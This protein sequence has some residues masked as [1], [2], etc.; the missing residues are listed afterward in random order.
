ML[1]DGIILRQTVDPGVCLVFA[2]LERRDFETQV[3]EA[4][5]DR[6]EVCPLDQLHKGEQ[7]AED[8]ITL[9]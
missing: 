4:V 2:T 9:Q 5:I 8:P 7:P 6:V 3:G 1:V